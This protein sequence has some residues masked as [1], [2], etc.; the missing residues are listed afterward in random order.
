M[1]CKNSR[2]EGEIFLVYSPCPAKDPPSK[3]IIVYF[4]FLLLLLGTCE[5]FHVA[6]HKKQWETRRQL[7]RAGRTRENV[8]R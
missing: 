5:V 6:C 7:S 8:A 2:K 3:F 1:G 4:S